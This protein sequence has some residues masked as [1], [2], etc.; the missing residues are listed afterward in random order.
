M[1]KLSRRAMLRGAGGVAVGLPFLGAMLDPLRSVAQSAEVPKRFVVFF[2][3]NGTIADRWRPTGG[4]TD[5]ELSD[6]L[7]P[8]EPHRDDIVI[9]EG[10]DMK[11]AIEHSGGQNGHDIGMG[12]ILVARPLVQGPSGF[13]EF[14]HLWD[15]SAGGKSLDQ[16]IADELGQT[17]RFRSLEFGYDT[18]IQQP[19]PSRMSWRGEFDPVPSMDDPGAAFDRVFAEGVQDP[20]R[21]VDLRDQRVTV[22]DAVLGDYRRLRRVL[23]P[24]DQRRVDQHLTALREIE[25]RVQAQDTSGAC[26]VPER[27]TASDATE[28]GQIQSDLMTMAMAC[29]LT[30][31]TS[32]QWTNGQGGLQA[33]WLGIERGHHD[34][35]HDGD[36]NAD[37]IEQL[38]A[39]NHFFAEQF[40]YLIAA[41]KA[42]TEADGQSLLDH[43][44]V[45]WCNELGKGNDHT[46]RDIPYVLAGSAGGAI[47][48]G[49][50]V[51]FG[52]DPHGNFY[53][54]LMQALGLGQTSFGDPDYCT[55]PLAGL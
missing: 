21:L 49:R 26:D 38:V 12:H 31:V 48:T 6:I 7:S 10:V 53:V 39:I 16:V 29:E 52:D 47:Q 23:G 34:L 18:G 14:G 28:H 50:F 51:R 36:S 9:V 24:E 54:S 45:L 1:R 27:R 46:Y 17:S 13:G 4:E 44:I 40:A 19:I 42:T 5:F 25:Q 43:S 22:L 37:T 8:L 2:S 41:M 35:S 15:G 30:P 3:P 11:T 55:G 33:S 20:Q 32:M